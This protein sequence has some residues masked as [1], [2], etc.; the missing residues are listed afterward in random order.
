MR[1]RNLAE[2]ALKS[3]Y[4]RSLEVARYCK[5]ALIE[6]GIPAWSNPGAITVVFPKVEE[7][8]KQK[9]QLA[10]EDE[11]THIICMPNVTK[12]QIDAFVEDVKIAQSYLGQSSVYSY[13]DF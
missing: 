13:A 9:W 12:A 6:I 2:K 4:Q 5:E 10:T 3:V 1:F 7:H 11:Q 8:I